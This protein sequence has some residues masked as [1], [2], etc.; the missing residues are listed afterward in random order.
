[1]S[2][3]MESTRTVETQRQGT[4]MFHQRKASLTTL[5][6]PIDKRQ[7]KRKILRSGSFRK[8]WLIKVFDMPVVQLVG[9]SYLLICFCLSTIHLLRSFSLLD[10][11]AGNI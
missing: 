10:P 7:E 4:N 11:N 8:S 2:R 1:M 9:W 6:A 3:L 5:C